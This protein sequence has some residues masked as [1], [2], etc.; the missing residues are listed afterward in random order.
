MAITKYGWISDKINGIS[1]NHTYP[2]NKKCYTSRPARNIDY[3][4]IHYTGN[5]DD[6]AANNAKYY[7]GTV[8]RAASAHLFVDEKNI[9]QSLKLR[10]IGWSI[11]CVSGYKTKARNSNSIS[12]E[13]C[14]DGK[15]IVNMATQINAAYLM[16]WLFKHYGW[17]SKD[18][19]KRILRHYDCVKSNKLCPK[20]YVDHPDQFRHFK[21][22]VKNII[23]T[24]TH[25]AHKADAHQYYDQP[26]VYRVTLEKHVIRN[27]PDPEAKI[28]GSITDKG[29][30]TIV[31]I[32]N[33]YGLLKAY[34]NS[35]DHWINLRTDYVKK[36][37]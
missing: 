7:S 15:G 27:Q 18:V 31:N 30:Y 1:V 13:M 26:G 21:D 34:E 23:D 29:S 37:K 14:T 2:C 17:K 12:I 36:V 22:M 32:K 19:D 25:T 8:A 24:G 35:Q 33:H 3:L 16:S 11:G 9:Y 5:D 10:W 28:V 6:C 4:I 20:Q